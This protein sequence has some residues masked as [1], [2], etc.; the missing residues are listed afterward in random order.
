PTLSRL[1]VSVGPG[2]RLRHRCSSQYLRISPLHWE[3]R[4][5]LPNSRHPVSKAI[6]RLSPGLSPLTRI[7]AYAPFTPSKSEQ[8]L[9]PPYYG[10]CGHGVSRGFFSRYRHHLRGRH[11]FPTL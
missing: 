6:P 11:S 8:R 9:P 10:G 2:S 4:Y 1:S 5:P 7:S 3:F